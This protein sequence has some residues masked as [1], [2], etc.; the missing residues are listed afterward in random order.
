MKSV[1][2]GYFGLWYRSC[3]DGFIVCSLKISICL[4]SGEERRDTQSIT[5][6][7]YLLSLRAVGCEE[8][9]AVIGYLIK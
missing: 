1:S 3:K 4:L 5:S 7:E 8:Y 6:N 9:G 2:R